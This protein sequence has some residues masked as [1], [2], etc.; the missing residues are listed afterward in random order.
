[1]KLLQ[2]FLVEADISALTGVV[3]AVIVGAALYT[4]DGVVATALAVAVYT[5]SVLD[6][7]AAAAADADGA[8]AVDTTLAVVVYTAFVA[9]AV[10]TASY[11][12]AVVRLASEVHLAAAD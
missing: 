9:P 8:Y 1:L 11:E 12:T 4:L 10:D 2:L 6:I 5:A 3:T 7:T